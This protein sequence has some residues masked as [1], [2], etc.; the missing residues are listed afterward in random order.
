MVI[1]VDQE[2][3]TGIRNQLLIDG[4]CEINMVGMQVPAE[5]RSQRTRPTGGEAQNA[6]VYKLQDGADEV[7][8]DDLTGQILDATLVHEAR[9]KELDDFE[10]KNVWLKKPISEARKATGKPPITV[11]WV[12]VNKG[13]DVQPN[14][15]S[16]LVAR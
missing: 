15:R 11:R 6:E 4:V 7:F 12:D 5:N 16:R 3:L 1:A 13:D 10:A 2:I 14:I 8:K 9:R